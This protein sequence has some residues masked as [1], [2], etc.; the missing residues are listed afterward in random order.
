[1]TPSLTRPSLSFASYISF[2]ID[3]S[4]YTLSCHL[5]TSHNALYC[6]YADDDGKRTCLLTVPNFDQL[7]THSCVFV[8]LKTLKCSE[9][10]FRT[11]LASSSSSVPHLMD[12]GDTPMVAESEEDI[13]YQDDNDDD[14]DCW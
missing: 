14:M 7:Q 8:N 12:T 5:A 9:I 10:Q 11:S 2:N 6:S 4:Y 1:M 3:S 13:N